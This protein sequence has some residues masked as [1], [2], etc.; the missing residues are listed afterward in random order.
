LGFFVHI[1]FQYEIDSEISSASFASG[2][3]SDHE[4]MQ[5][6]HSYQSTDDKALYEESRRLVEE[7]EARIADLSSGNTTI[8]ED[9]HQTHGKVY[10]LVSIRN[11]SKYY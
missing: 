11:V 8:I 1:D 3:P 7:L 6:S 10:F 2:P 5:G 9:E 4:D